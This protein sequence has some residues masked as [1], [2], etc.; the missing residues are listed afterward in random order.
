MS[1]PVALL[2]SDLKSL[3]GL[4]FL[5]RT[6][7]GLHLVAA[8]K[9]GRFALRDFPIVNPRVVLVEPNLRDQP[10]FRVIAK[11][12][13]L[14]PDV[15][16]LFL[17]RK[18]DASGVP[19]AIFAGAHGIL[20]AGTSPQQML[21][22]IV[23]LDRGE[24]WLHPTASRFLIEHLHLAPKNLEGAMKLSTRE[25]DVIRTYIGGYRCKEVATRLGVSPF[26]VQAHVRSIYTKLNARSMAH[27]VVLYSPL[28]NLKT[29]W[30]VAHGDPSTH[31]KV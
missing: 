15:R 28:L 14:I 23:A 13:S 16:I 2:N 7:P 29:T 24:V 18:L 3:E 5:I 11:I 9:S 8:S 6:T 10:S 20:P 19:M 30:D 21:E 12:R 26:T 22:A 1:I 25:V 27:A 17:Q 4:T 31:V